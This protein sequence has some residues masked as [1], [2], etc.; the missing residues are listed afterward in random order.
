MPVV[1]AGWGISEP[2]SHSLIPYVFVAGL[3]K[4]DHVVLTSSRGKLLSPTTG[5]RDKVNSRE[6][7][8]ESIAYSD[9][10]S[11]IRPVKH[12]FVLSE[13]FAEVILVEYRIKIRDT[14]PVVDYRYS[15][16]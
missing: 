12:L 5:Q 15:K 7:R 2:H 8:S 13:V 10:D 3:D 16:V 11:P 9:S 14:A 4:H 1:S 6:R